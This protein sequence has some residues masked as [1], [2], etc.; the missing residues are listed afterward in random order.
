MFSRLLFIGTSI[1]ALWV[2]GGTR[3]QP[4][5]PAEAW[6]R[7]SDDG[8]TLTYAGSATV[9]GLHTRLEARF[10]CN[11]EKTKMTTGAIGFNLELKDTDAMSSFHFDDFEGADAPASKRQLM[12]VT[13]VRA[14][15]TPL[16]FRTSP[17]GST[18]IG[19]GFM[20]EVSDVFYGKASTARKVLEALRTEASAMNVAIVDYR[21]NSTRI[22]LTIPMTGR[23]D[24]F[25]WLL[26][27]LP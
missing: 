12:T 9:L 26:A 13:V 3:A 20:F 2:S 24:D 22:E 16:H 17:A 14:N 19:G 10:Y 23:S 21:V 11:T 6:S 8:R 18:P 7:K 1:A 5:K 25:R 15:G 27:R 4:A